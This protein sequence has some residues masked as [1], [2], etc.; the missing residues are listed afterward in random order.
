MDAADKTRKG[1]EMDTTTTL[2]EKYKAL[3]GA[4]KSQA[5]ACYALMDLGVSAADAA[6][7]AWQAVGQ[8]APDRDDAR[9]VSAWHRG[10]ERAQR[11]W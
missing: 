5:D 8:K 10:Q 3:I 11:G 4:G 9:A 1:T 2:I 6:A 7:V